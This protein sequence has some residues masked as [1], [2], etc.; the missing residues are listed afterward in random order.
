MN[1]ALSDEQVFLQEAARTALGRTDTIEAAR[2]ALDGGTL[3]DL[4]PVSREAGWPGLLVCEDR[5]GAG[6]GVF[7]AML[8][9][10]ELG[11]V[12]APVALLGH[13]PATWL[14]D[15]ADGPIDLVGRLA[16]GEARAAFMPARPPDGIHDAWT[17]EGHRG[18]RRAAVP[19]LAGGT[20]SGAV[21]WVPDAAGADV[22]VGVADDAGTARAVLVEAGDPG[23]AVEAVTRYDATRPLGHVQLDGARATVLEGLADDA[24]AG[25]WYLAQALLAAE[26]QGSVEE[27]LQRSV[28]YAKERFTFGRPIGSYQAVKHALVEVLRRLE[29]LR[30]LVYY[31]GWAGD[32]KPD[33]FPLAASAARV[34]AGA[35]QDYA[36][37]E[38]I[39]VHGGIGATW[40]HDAPLFFRRAQLARRLLGGDGDAADRVADELL[41][42]TAAARAIAA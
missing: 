7:D 10:T 37:R 11:R 15:R 36:A 41:R 40:E 34:A 27:A 30:S 8:V 24:P 22:L 42:G 39:S 21:H 26:A 18:S 13:L 33:E 4:W 1:L 5:G 3:P 19:A 6:L 35:A 23:V 2:D 17:V 38:L 29:N 16:E 25:A 31:A 9:M 12:L 28:E 14:M 32:D 20:V